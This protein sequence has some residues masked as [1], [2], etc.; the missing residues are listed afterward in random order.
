M[1]LCVSQGK[2][3]VSREQHA[4]FTFGCC[5]N[6]TGKWGRVGA[7]EDS[8]DSDSGDQHQGADLTLLFSTQAY[9]QFL[10]PLGY[11]YVFKNKLGPS[12]C[13]YVCLPLGLYGRG[14][15][16]KSSVRTGEA[17]STWLCWEP[18]QIT[19][20]V[21]RTLEELQKPMVFSLPPLFQHQVYFHIPH[22][23]SHILE[24]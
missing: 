5:G 9:V 7:H 6:R 11:G 16:W 21:I 19:Y 24:S 23:L 12:I 4:G 8:Q 13:S 20:R 14:Q 15:G 1:T 2:P 17:A 22:K 18:S 10:S 3:L